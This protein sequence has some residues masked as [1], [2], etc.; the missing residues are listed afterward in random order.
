MSSITEEAG[1]L[2]QALA[3]MPDNR[4]NAGKRY[5]LARLLTG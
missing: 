4:R 2:W 5:P 1:S 3:S